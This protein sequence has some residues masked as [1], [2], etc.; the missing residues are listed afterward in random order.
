MDEP[1][2]EVVPVIR[3]EI[4]VFEG[5]VVL[6]SRNVVLGLKGG[7]RIESVVFSRN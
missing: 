5:M 6:G 3:K 1:R 7:K 4:W 2:G